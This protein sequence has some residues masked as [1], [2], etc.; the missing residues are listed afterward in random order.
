MTEGLDGTRRH[1]AISD[2]LLFGTEVGRFNNFLETKSSEV[3]SFLRNKKPQTVG[4]KVGK[5][6]RW[7]RA[8]DSRALHLGGG[9]KKV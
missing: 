4:A 8:G 9:P 3:V 5:T 2:E 6:G 1:E 7:E